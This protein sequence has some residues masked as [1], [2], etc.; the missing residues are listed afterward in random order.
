MIM[1]KEAAKALIGYKTMGPRM[2]KARFHTASGKTTIVQVY[3]PTSS[4]TEQEMDEFY[5]A[6]QQTVQ[7]IS[8]QDLTIIMGDMNAKVGKDWRTWRGALGK[9]GYGEENERGERM[10]KFC[11]NNNL[12]IMNTVSGP[13]SV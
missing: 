5:E 8:S 11:L 1:K 2:I 7:E 13:G 6:L 4:A 3:A 9:Q 10:L 12:Q